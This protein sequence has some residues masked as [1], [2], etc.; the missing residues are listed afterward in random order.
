[1]NKWTINRQNSSNW[2]TAYVPTAIQIF[3][4]MHW[5]PLWLQQ[6]QSVTSECNFIIKTTVLIQNLF[7]K[8][9]HWPICSVDQKCDKLKLPRPKWQ[10]CTDCRNVMI[11][12]HSSDKLRLAVWNRLWSI[13]N[14]HQITHTHTHTHTLTFCC[15]Q[16]HCL[17]NGFSLQFNNTRNQTTE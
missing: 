3:I 1:M 4:N 6:L 8:V 12:D 13:Q 16:Q 11:H 10:Y 14:L 5:C 17:R 9:W 2:L 7:V 15:R